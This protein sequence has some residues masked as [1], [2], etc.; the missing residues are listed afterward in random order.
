MLV[1]Y[2]IFIVFYSSRVNFGV[3]YF[4][5]FMFVYVL[6]KKS[7]C[8]YMFT[9]VISVKSVFLIFSHRLSALIEDPRY[10]ITEMSIRFYSG[11]VAGAR[12]ALICGVPSLSISLNW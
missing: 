4:I 10:L 11:V 2:S 9:A 5:Q 7:L 12:E 1:S 6:I 8:L 3:T